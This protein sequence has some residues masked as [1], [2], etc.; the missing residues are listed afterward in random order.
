MTIGERIKTLRKKNDMTQEKLADFL[1]VSYQAVSKWE[2]GIASPDLSLIVPLTRLFNVSADELLGLTNEEVDERKAYFDAEYFDF[3]MKD[4]S[5]ADLEIAR[6]AVAEYPSDFRYLHWLASDEWYVGYSPKYYNTEKGKELL[7]SSVKHNLMILEN[8]DEPDIKKQAI[9]GLVYTYSSMDNLDE[10]K[11]YA[12]MYPEDGQ[13]DRDDLLISC[14]RGEEQEALRKKIFH[15]KLI[16]LSFSL[17]S[18][19]RNSVPPFH[20]ALDAHETIIKAIITDGNYQRLHGYL[21]DIYLERAKISMQNDAPDEA[22]KNLTVCLNHANEFDKM[23]KMGIE[24]YTCP[25]LKGYRADYRNRRVL[26][27]THTEYIRDCIMD[28]KLFASLHDK[29]VLK[30]MLE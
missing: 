7:E 25:I 9:S 3:W 22:I 28:D 15:K 5:E 26:E 19:W 14:L 29:E 17:E 8:C 20:E 16:Q 4:D 10:A 2:C 30:K 13:I 27:F 11:K 18:L 21:S 12:E 6:Q 1:H 23:D 24:E